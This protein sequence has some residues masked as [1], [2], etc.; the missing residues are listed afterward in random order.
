MVDPIEISRRIRRRIDESGLSAD[1]AADVN[2]V[3][4]SGG[5][6]ATATQHAPINQGRSSRAARAAPD[7]KEQP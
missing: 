6:T 7:A 3:V 1:V 4:S 5:G 2:I